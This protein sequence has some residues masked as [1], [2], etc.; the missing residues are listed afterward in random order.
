M[1]K[2]ILLFGVVFSIITVRSQNVGVG[3]NAPKS[4][5]DVNG[6]LT[7]G[8]TYSGVTAAPANAALIQGTVA[9]TTP[10]PD[11]SAILDMSGSNKGVRFPQV[12]LTGI[13]D[14]TIITTPAKGLVVWNTAASWCD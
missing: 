8:S 11:A 2:A 12:A 3:T 13:S 5:L 7:V 14:G 10:S 1:K 4:K 9:I 6:G